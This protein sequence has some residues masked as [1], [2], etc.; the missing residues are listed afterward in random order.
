MTRALRPTLQVV[1][2]ARRLAPEPRR[3]FKQALKDLA[4]D[5]GDIK[6]L[7]GNL[8][9]L[10]RLKVGRHRII[11]SYAEDGA[12]DAI[13]AEKRS[14]VYEVFEAEFIMRLRKGAG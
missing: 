6:P 4:H 12:I 9:G 7:D 1:D 3:R 2:Y 14:L 8:S 13:F 11:F 10:H 5:R